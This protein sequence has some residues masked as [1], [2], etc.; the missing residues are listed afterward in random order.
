MGVGRKKRETFSVGG[1]CAED[2]LVIIF[3][4]CESDLVC[5]SSIG[6]VLYPL[7]LTAGKPRRKESF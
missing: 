1:N 6:D 2:V 5:K 4:A 3:A 7:S